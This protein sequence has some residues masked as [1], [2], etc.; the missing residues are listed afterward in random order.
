MA[1]SHRLQQA[2]HAQRGVGT[3]L[4]RV[5]PVVVYTLEQTMY[6]LQALQGLEVELFASNRQVVALHQTQAQIAGQI[7]MFKISFVVGAWREQSNVGRSPGRAASLHAI[8]QGTVSFG[9]ALH[10]ES[11][12]GLREK[13]RNNEPVF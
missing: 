11:L 2:R 4:K 8:D 7:S 12:K 10:R 1:A 5:Q 9:Q 6:G 13:P 3:H